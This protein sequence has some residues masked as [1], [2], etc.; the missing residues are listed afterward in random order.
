MLE[1]PLRKVNRWQIQNPDEATIFLAKKARNAANASGGKRI[2]V[3]GGDSDLTDAVCR[4]LAAH[5]IGVYRHDIKSL[6]AFFPAELDALGG[7][8]CTYTDIRRSHAVAR[9]VLATPAL[10]HLTFECVVL[11]EADYRSLRRH[12]RHAATDFVSPLPTYPVDVFAI[13]EEAL[14]HFTP[15][16]D[17]RDFM[18]ICQLLDSLGRNQVP[19]AIAEFGSFQGHSGYLM[20][21]FLH[22]CAASRR[23]LLFDTFDRFPNEPLGIDHF[24]SGSHPVDFQA[25]RRKFE[26]FPFVE[27]F[28]GDFTTTFDQAGVDQLSLAYVDCDSFRATDFL[29]RRLF[30]DILAPGGILVIEDYGHPQLLGS[31]AAVHRY[32]DGRPGCVPFFSQFS[33]LYIVIK[34]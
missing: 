32:F 34:L 8:I 2:L 27:L 13:Y 25:L 6:D 7:V 9:I 29:L 30:P 10:Q 20:A 14:E 19:G 21:D 23:L 17:L 28:R 26:R 16:C 3:I 24:W 12:D 5:R 4:D 33:G 11:P 18:D 1:T 22:R 15:K 31:R